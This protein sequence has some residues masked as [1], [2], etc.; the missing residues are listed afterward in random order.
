MVDG[1]L[2]RRRPWR[3]VGSSMWMF[4]GSIGG[5]HVFV[6]CV[7]GS[8]CRRP[9]RLPAGRRESRRRRGG[10]VRERETQR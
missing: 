3:T 4:P 2:G 6:R 1:E 9:G 8:P 10:S 5:R 7:G